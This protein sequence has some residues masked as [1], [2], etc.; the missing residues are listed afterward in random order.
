MVSMLDPGLTCGTVPAPRG[1]QAD[2]RAGDLPVPG[3]NN[4]RAAHRTTRRRQ[5]SLLAS[6]HTVPE[7][8]SWVGIFRPR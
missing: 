1:P 3:V 5:D 7:F 8:R 6:S 4:Q 2:R